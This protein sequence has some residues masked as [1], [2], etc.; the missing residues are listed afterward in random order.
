MKQQ[1]LKI[2]EIRVW[3]LG[4]STGVPLHEEPQD[5]NPTLEDLRAEIGRYDDEPLDDGPGWDLGRY[6]EF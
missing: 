5:E 4:M 2:G 3:D 6:E 1:P